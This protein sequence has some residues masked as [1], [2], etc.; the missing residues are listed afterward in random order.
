MALQ[1][2][3]RSCCRFFFLWAEQQEQQY[4]ETTCRIASRRRLESDEKWVVPHNLVAAL[5]SCSTVNVMVFDHLHGADQARLYAC[6]YVR[7][8]EPLYFME[9]TCEELWIGGE[10][11]GNAML[12]GSSQRHAFHFS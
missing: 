10:R 6:K 12:V 8:P 11:K 7:K 3:Y 9:T 5:Y 2:Q 1:L 4:C